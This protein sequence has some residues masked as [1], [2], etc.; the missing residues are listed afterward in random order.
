MDYR[1]VLSTLDDAARAEELARALLADRLVAC[2]TIVGP[3]QSLY[4]WEGQIAHDREY[5]L[6][7]KTVASRLDALQ[8]RLLELHPYE[9]PEVLALTVDAGAPDYLAWLRTSVEAS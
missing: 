7:M 2:V 4:H 8:K 5:L 1:I 9:V 3:V 6:V